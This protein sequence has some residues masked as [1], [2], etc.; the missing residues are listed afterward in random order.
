MTLSRASI[1]AAAALLAVAGFAGDS[2]SKG[3][4]EDQGPN[5]ESTK[6]PGQ[7]CEQFKKDSDAYKSCVGA[8]AKTY[9]PEGGEMGTGMGK[10]QGMEH[11]Q[12]MDKGQGMES[13]H[14]MGKGMEMDDGMGKGKGM[15]MDDGMGHGKGMGQ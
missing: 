5:A 4:P 12:G 2:W 15:N 9:K 14:G 1:F 13:D 10:G 6:I 3:K 8:A 7:N 11:G